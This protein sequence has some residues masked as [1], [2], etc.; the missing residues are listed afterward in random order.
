MRKKILISIIVLTAGYALSGCTQTNTVPDDDEANGEALIN[1]Q[2]SQNINNAVNTANT[3]NPNRGDILDVENVNVNNVNSVVNISASPSP[4]N[5]E[6]VPVAVEPNVTI[7]A[8]ANKNVY[9]SNESITLYIVLTSNQDLSDL[10]IHASGI[11]SRW[12]DRYFDLT[13]TIEV[14]KNSPTNFSFIS[15]LPECSSCSGIVPGDY[16]I[17]VTAM[18][19]AKTLAT[20]QLIINLQQ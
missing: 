1:A 14:T 19:E 4:V 5:K 18:H 3:A 17:N 16:T 11:E 20:N 12:G 7:Q 13:K 9:Y 10:I 15:M 6:L 8:S 2:T